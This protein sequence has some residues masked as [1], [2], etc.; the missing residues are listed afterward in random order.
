MAA[1]APKCRSRHY[2]GSVD[3][4]PLFV[5][6]AGLYVERTGDDETLAELWPSN[7][8]GITLDRR[9]R[10]SRP[11]RIRRISA[12]R[13]KQG[14]ANQGW[15]DSY[16]AIF[17]ADGRPRRRLHRAWRKCRAMSSPANNLRRRCALRLGPLRTRHDSLEAEARLLAGALWKPRSG[18]TSSAPT[19]LA[20]DGR[21][22][23]LQGAYIQC[24][25]NCCS[26]ASSARIA[27]GWSP[28]DLM[29]PHFFHRL[30][31]SA[32]VAAAARR[33][34]IRCPIMDGSIWPHDNALIALGL[35]ALRPQT[36]RVDH[37]FEGPCSVRATYMDLR[38]LPELF[39]RFSAREGDAGRTLLPGRLRRRRPGRAQP[40]F[41]LL[42]A[43]LGLEFD[44]QRG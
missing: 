17:H 34:I 5:L 15:K 23:A 6:L 9:G 22:A 31:V 29:R 35:G 41:T 38:R 19:P 11:R 7:R 3:A 1:A 28:A 8:S 39:L 26:P 32:T 12:P 21:Q 44:A 13:R 43:A 2:Y 24:G 25:D 36:L 30:G 37:V 10:R 27:P 33:A 42:E 4:T 14:L 16:D 20:L 18:A 40:P